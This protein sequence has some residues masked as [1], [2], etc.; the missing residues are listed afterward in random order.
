MKKKLIIYFI[1]GLFL[2]NLFSFWKPILTWIWNYFFEKWIYPVSLAINNFVW[3]DIWNY[4][5]WNVF[6]KE[7]MYQKALESYSQVNDKKL[8]FQK[9]HNIWNTNYRLWEN[10]ETQKIKYF[11]DAVNAYKK[12][13][14]IKE[15]KETRK[16][17]EFVENKLKQNQE[18]KEEE[19]QEEKKE[20]NNQENKD[21]K[22]SENKSWTWSQENT[23]SWSWNTNEIEN[24]TWTWSQENSNSWSWNTNSWTENQAWKVEEKLWKDIKNEL[25]EYEKNLNQNQEYY[26]DNLWKKYNDYNDLDPFSQLQQRWMDPFFDNSILE[27]NNTEKSW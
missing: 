14:E 18:E 9:Y 17:L 11:T 4:N 27:E 24:Q 1:L 12:A 20:E 16:N 15:D 5:N 3:N 22:S 8:G 7:K 19:K 25:K 26:R 13:L 10:D 6:Y 2:V 23:N 21:N